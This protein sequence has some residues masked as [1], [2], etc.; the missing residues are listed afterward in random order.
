M[1][2]TI[3]D[4]V[5]YVVWGLLWYEIAPCVIPVLIFFYLIAL[6]YDILEKRSQKNRFLKF[7]FY[8]YR[9]ILFLL[10]LLF[11]ILIFFIAFHYEIFNFQKCGSFYC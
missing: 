9:F 11:H 8:F 4:N 5:F 1:L 2:I 7:I 6:L 10:T 3:L